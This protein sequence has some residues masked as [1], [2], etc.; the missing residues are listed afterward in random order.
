MGRWS[1]LQERSRMCAFITSGTKIYMYIL[2]LWND[3]NHCNVKIQCGTIITRWVFSQ[4]LTKG[5]PQLVHE[6][7]LLGSFVNLNSDSCA[8]SVTAVLYAVPS[9]NIEP[10]YNDTRLFIVVSIHPSHN[11]IHRNLTNLMPNVLFQRR[12]LLIFNATIL[13]Y[14]LASIG[15]P[16]IEIRWNPFT[17]Q[18]YTPCSS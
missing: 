18:S 1:P 5:T 14:R 2:I 3:T 7:T 15:F 8:A 16:V 11:V 6:D 10:C 9:Y 4:I 13:K 17:I 12:Q